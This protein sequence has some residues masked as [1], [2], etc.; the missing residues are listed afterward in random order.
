MHINHSRNHVQFVETVELQVVIKAF[1]YNRISFG[2]EVLQLAT[3]A[4]RRRVEDL[5]GDPL[6]AMLSVIKS[7][8]HIKINEAQG[9]IEIFR[10][11]SKDPHLVICTVRATVPKK[12]CGFSTD[13]DSAEL[14]E[15]E[16]H[17]AKLIEVENERISQRESTN[18]QA[19][20]SRG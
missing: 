13:T 3:E 19:A 9:T 8:P 10:F 12:V 16:Q 5:V 20:Y 2:S 6:R 11:V 4:R 15:L 14:L 17:I 1:P 18:T 7:I